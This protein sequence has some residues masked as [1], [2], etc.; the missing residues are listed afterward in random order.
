M[1]NLLIAFIRC[2]YDFQLIKIYREIVIG[3]IKFEYK[4]WLPIE[5]IINKLNNNKDIVPILHFILAISTNF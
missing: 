4:R 1:H 2:S 3:I 5:D